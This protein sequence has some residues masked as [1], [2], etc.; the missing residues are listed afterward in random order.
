MVKKKAKIVGKGRLP[1]CIALT[2]IFAF[3]NFYI[4]LP[5]LNLHNPEFYFFVLICVLVFCFLTLLTGDYSKAAEEGGGFRPIWKRCKW[6]LLVCGALLALMILGGLIGSVVFRSKDY[7][8]LMKVEAGDFANEV[9]EIS[10][11]KIPMLDSASA[12]VLGN[13][14]LGELADMVSQFEVSDTYYQI[15]YKD[16]PMRVATL[17]YGDFFKWINNMKNGLPG[18]VRIN[19]VTQNAEIIRLQDG[20]KYSTAD[21]FGRNLNR[22]LRFRYPTWMFDDPVFEID[23]EG[24]PWYICAREIRTIGLFGGRDVDGAV[25]VNAVTGESKYYDKED[26]PSWVDR[27]YSASLIIEQY[28]YYGEYQS[29][30]LNSLFG[31]RG[32]TAT[33]DGY[34]YIALND[35]VYVYTGV[36]SLGGDE[37]NVGF[38]LCNQRTKECRYYPCAGA[39]EYS[40]MD[41][42]MGVVQHLQYNATFPLLLNVGGQPTYFMSL[43]DAAGLVKMYAMVNVQQYNIVATG[44]SVAECENAYS[45]LLRQDGLTTSTLSEG[46]RGRIAEIRT[47]VID[48]NS[49]YYFRLV[50][51]NCFYSVSAERCETAVILNVDDR[52]AIYGAEEE[53]DIRPADAIEKKD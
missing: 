42:A 30:F 13:R 5:A 46:I 49:W 48:G 25:L 51:E 47:A 15:N 6:P 36:T 10:Y 45:K 52:V 34:N 37:S 21:H 33:T 35:D 23:D 43:K 38:L 41:S 44:N 39:E 40:A 19:M 29:G 4:T 32:C 7:T 9:D 16:S 22:L 14:K 20:M 17:R 26:V 27:V 8:E 11:N 1:L 50:G 53:G 2:L 3:L 31:Q 12:A 28:D 24:Q 18:Y